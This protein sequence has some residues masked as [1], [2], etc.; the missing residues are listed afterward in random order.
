MKQKKGAFET[1]DTELRKLIHILYGKG[2]RIFNL[3]TTDPRFAPQGNGFLD[4]FDDEAETDPFMGVSELLKTTREIRRALPRDI[5]IVGTGL[6]WFGPFSAFAAAGGVKQHWFDI[7]GFGRSVM[8]DNDFIPS[9]LE[10]R[11]PD[12]SRACVGCDSCFQ[13]FYADLPTGC[14]VNHKAWGDLYKAASEKGIL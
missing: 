14:P 2:V 9:I 3:S 1:D 8:T 10:G 11:T 6:S 7:A 13:L 5:L 4:C 12:R